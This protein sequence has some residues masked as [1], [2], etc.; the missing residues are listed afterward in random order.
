[1]PFLL[2]FLSFPLLYSLQEVTLSKVV[3]LSP[4]LNTKPAPNLPD[5]FHPNP[6]AFANGIAAILDRCPE[7]IRK[8]ADLPARAS[9]SSRIRVFRSGT[10]L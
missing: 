7:P 4:L 10:F 1:L 3:F 8:S 5:Q 2:L 6:S 9:I